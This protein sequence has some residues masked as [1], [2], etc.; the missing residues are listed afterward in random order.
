MWGVRGWLGWMTATLIESLDK[1]FPFGRLSQRGSWHNIN[2]FGD[3]IDFLLSYCV[4]PSSPALYGVSSRNVELDYPKKKPQM[5]FPSPGSIVKSKHCHATSPVA[6]AILAVQSALCL[7]HQFVV[8]EKK[9]GS[10]LWLDFIKLIFVALF[11]STMMTVPLIT[12]II[13]ADQQQAK[14]AVDGNVYTRRVRFIN[15][16]RYFYSCW[17]RL[18]RSYPEMLGGFLRNLI[19]FSAALLLHYRVW[20]FVVIF[21]SLFVIPKKAS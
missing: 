17:Q 15:C 8:S 19:I 5:D 4:C 18:A 7:Q 1:V 9:S 10:V 13:N 11:C 16:L 3:F 12:W 21:F 20:F 2:V 14:K 6:N